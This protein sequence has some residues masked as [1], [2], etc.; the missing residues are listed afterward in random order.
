MMAMLMTMTMLTLL[1]EMI[2]T[3]RKEVGVRSMRK[4]FE[5]HKK[6]VGI[7]AAMTMMTT[8]NYNNSKNNL[9]SQDQ[10]TNKSFFW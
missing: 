9:T 10:Y 3:V 2:D 6:I 5:R 4:L 7:E 8:N 1:V